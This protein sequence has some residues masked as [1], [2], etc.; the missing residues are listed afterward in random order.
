MKVRSILLVLMLV[1]LF[2]FQI[3]VPI[4]SAEITAKD[5]RVHISGPSVL[6]TENSGHYSATIVDPQNRNWNYQ[7]FITEDNTTGASPLE[8]SPATG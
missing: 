7:V 1:A 2:L 4:T 5:V 6:G 8:G 3:A